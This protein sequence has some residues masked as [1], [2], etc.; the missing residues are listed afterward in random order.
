MGNKITLKIISVPVNGPGGI[1][2]IETDL[3]SC[4][5]G[6][7]VPAVPLTH[8]K[9]NFSWMTLRHSIGVSRGQKLFLTDRCSGCGHPL[10]KAVDNVSIARPC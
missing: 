3:L 7:I 2:E 6:G 8:A 10:L 4:E 9:E 1:R 5:V